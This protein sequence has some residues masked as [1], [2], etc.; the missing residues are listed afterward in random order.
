MK[1]SFLSSMIQKGVPVE[2]VRPDNQCSDCGGASTNVV[3]TSES[4]QDLSKL[5]AQKAVVTAKIEPNGGT[6]TIIGRGPLGELFTEALQKSYKRVTVNADINIGNEGLD[7]IDSN[8]IS[9]NG[10]V[11]PASSPESTIAA[12][13]RIMTGLL[14]PI[15]DNANPTCLNALLQA[16]N[17]VRN[18]EFVFVHDPALGKSPVQET[19]EPT[20][21][22][23]IP[24][25]TGAQSAVT[26]AVESVQIVIKL[27]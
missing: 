23:A 6:T 26:A 3:A 25:D 8:R 10:Q 19:M 2:E 12:R 21:V 16:M 13:T 9:A 14:P 4:G 24:F 7:G 20:G 15:D 5:D 17:Q 22:K 11:L 27:K 18:V 1:H